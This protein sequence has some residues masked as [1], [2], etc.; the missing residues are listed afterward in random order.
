MIRSVTAELLVTRKR[1][2]T[3]ILLGTW[4][5]LGILF[6]YLTPYLTISGAAQGKPG[7]PLAL[8]LPERLADNLFGR[9]PLLRRRDRADAGSAGRG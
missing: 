9:L 7:T 5:L 4:V 8:L 1:A 6:A 3:W 2:S